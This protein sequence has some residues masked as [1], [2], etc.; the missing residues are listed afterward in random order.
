MS[1][2]FTP[3]I[4]G[5]GEPDIRFDVDFSKSK[6]NTL[7]RHQL[8]KITGLVRCQLIIFFKTAMGT[9]GSYPDIELGTALVDDCLRAYINVEA[10]TGNDF[11]GTGGAQVFEELNSYNAIMDFVTTTDTTYTI[12]TNAPL[13]GLWEILAWYSPISSGSSVEIGNGT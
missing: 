10:I 7:G 1:T 6:W 9:V 8:L 11:W 2:P 5:Q 12:L 3:K 13:S 4:L